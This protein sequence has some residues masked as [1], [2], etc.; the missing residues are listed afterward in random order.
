MVTR[1]PQL[2]ACVL[3]CPLSFAAIAGA[4]TH[5]AAEPSAKPAASV[6]PA[7]HATAKHAGTA[8]ASAAT[9]ASKSGQ[10]ASASGGSDGPPLLP[11]PHK[12]Y[13]DAAANRLYWPMDKPFW[14]RLATSADPNAPSFLLKRVAPESN[15][16]TADYNKQ[17]I[18]LEIQGKQF[19]RW[20]NYVTKQTVNL[21]FFT[22]GAPPVTTATCTGA[23]TAVVASTTYYG[24][25]LE[26]A[27]AS[28]DNLSGVAH[29]YYSLDDHAWQPYA[30]ALVFD[31]E[32]PVTLRYYAVD[33]VGYAEKPLTMR[34][35]VDLTPPDT[36]DAIT[37]NA[38]G[39][40]LSTQADFRIT[41]TDAL[42][43]VASVM[44]RFD[45]QDYAPVV[46]EQVS[47]SKLP[48]GEHTLSYYAVDRVSNQETA[49]VVHFYLDR[50]PPVVQAHVIGDKYI[51]PDGTR[52]VSARSLV[53]LTAHDNKIGVQGI[54]YQ[55]E[56]QP[57][58]SYGQP[59]NLPPTSGSAK[60]LYRATDRLGNISDI[61]VLPYT[62]DITAPT[63]SYRI[64][65]PSYRERSDIYITQ[66][67]RIELSA[68]DDLSGVKEIQY[69]AVGAAEPTT[70]TAPFGFATEGRRMLRYWSTDRV[71]NRETDQAL[72]LITD[73]TPPKI[74]ANFSLSPTTAS[75]PEGLPVY[76]TGT[77]LFLGATD[78]ASG[79]QQ[80]YYRIDGGK[81]QEYKTPLTL[82]RPGKYDLLI[83]ADDNLGNES[84]KDLK[85]VING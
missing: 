61:S 41:S 63:T 12:V 8:G 21:E 18:S 47:V 73:N 30:T 72:V 65:G 26:C 81:E 11:H 19:I 17:G 82:N 9:S 54:T 25:G 29:T 85:F 66:A 38:I 2:V 70:Y 5:K 71:N 22:D 45:D 75:G 50:L 7:H 78:N 52:Y 15:E 14:V 24:K 77:S 10:A 53:K 6:H 44:A 16:T 49:H 46:N 13:V 59:F 33:H 40:V 76:R 34:F 43:G 32:K 39:K 84:T 51:A 3:V 74:F 42:S 55:F 48:D 83:R 56:K 1:F 28:Q 4:Q 62:M 68:T 36:V 23:P 20:F 80:I 79:V 35:I 64:T 37:G 69:Q 31:K 58:E 67:T 60:L 27:L 57:F